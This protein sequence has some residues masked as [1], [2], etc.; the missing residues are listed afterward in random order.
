VGDPSPLTS[1]LLAMP[2]NVIADGTSQ[3]T[4]T[5]TLRDL[6]NNPVSGQA[7]TLSVSGTGNTLGADGGTSDAT[8]AFSTTLSSTV[9]EMKTVTANAAG[10]SLQTQVTFI[11]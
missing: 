9:P 4:L 6:G 7:I 11:P 1:T 10:V 3:T 5:V 2:V 8:G